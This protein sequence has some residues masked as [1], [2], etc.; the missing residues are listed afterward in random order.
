ML[1]IFSKKPFF[2]EWVGGVKGVRKGRGFFVY[3]VAATLGV[4][5]ATLGVGIVALG[6]IIV[7][8]GVGIV[9]LGAVIEVKGER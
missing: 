7:A 5:I 4:G 6:V 9:A 2:S 8:L 1:A 3:V